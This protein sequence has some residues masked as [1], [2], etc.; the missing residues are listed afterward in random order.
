MS[1]LTKKNIPSDMGYMMKHL[2]LCKR[3]ICLSTLKGGT[4]NKDKFMN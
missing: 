3:I 4:E 1:R 2:Q